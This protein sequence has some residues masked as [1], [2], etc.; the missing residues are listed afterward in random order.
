MKFD[1]QIR[2]DLVI[3]MI[4]NERKFKDSLRA[5]LAENLPKALGT[6]D[7]SAKFPIDAFQAS[8]KKI[9][10]DQPLFKELE[11]AEIRNLR[12]NQTEINEQAQAEGALT[13]AR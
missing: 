4:A 5:E 2:L 7:L 13:Y 12:F 11:E 10:K 6:T 1:N 8:L 3:G 9:S